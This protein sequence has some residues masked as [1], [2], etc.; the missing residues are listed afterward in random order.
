LLDSLLKR[1]KIMDSEEKFFKMYFEKPRRRA[2]LGRDVSTLQDLSDR[3]SLQQ[4][5]PVKC[6]HRLSTYASAS[7]SRFSPLT[8]I[9][10][11]IPILN[12]LPKYNVRHDLLND[13]VAG[14]TVAVMHIPQG[15]A[16]GLLAGVDPVVGI[17]TAFFPVLVYVL[18]GTMP[19]VSMGSFAVVSIL[20]SKTVTEWGVD[21]AVGDIP[22]GEYS[23]I[24][25]LAA[26]TF[27]VGVM[28]LLA[29]LCRLGFMSVLLTDTLVSA[30]TVGA[31][32]HVLTSQI[33]H[34]LGLSIARQSG[35]GQLVLTYVE[36]G[37]SVKS[38]N[39]VTLAISL[40]VM[41]TC[42]VA[43]R[44]IGPRLKAKCRF[45][46]PTQLALII[47]FTT[48]SKVLGFQENYHVKTI[49]DI[50]EIPVGLPSPSYPTPE[51]IPKVFGAC[52]VPG[53]VS[54]VVGLGLGKMF[55]QK[56]GYEV[57]SN[58][59]LIAQ[60]TSNLVGS[61]FSCIPMAGSL[62][63]SVVQEAS[64]CR[65]LLTSLTSALLLLSVMLYLGPFFLPLP[66]S[67]LASIIVA[68]LY[69]IFLK[70]GEVG[71]YWTLNVYEGCIWLLT[72]CSTVFI[73][74]DYG[75]IIGVISTLALTAVQG[76]TPR[77]RV[78]EQ[79]VEEDSCVW[80]DNQLF[81]TRGG[82]K[83]VQINGPLHFLALDMVRARIRA[84][85]GVGP[86]NHYKISGGDL[87]L[88][89]SGVSYLDYSAAGLV[90]WLDGVL[91]LEEGR[92]GL[93]A[94]PQQMQTL[95]TELEAFPTYTDA[96]VIL[97]G[98][99]NSSNISV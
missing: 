33:K 46:L 57:D 84:E 14:F 55:G 52:I 59:E 77:V 71:K 42:L 15:M 29:G 10:S 28:Q 25:V 82:T 49:Q 3:Y 93:V 75:L 54:F 64:G 88:D 8:L 22:E 47:I 58:Q 61:I 18:L 44:I 21:P 13:L 11:I 65:T 7:C 98:N 78:L 74:I 24:Q 12:W 9:T 23:R 1:L 27:C 35:A 56:H 4:T 34:I 85:L 80:L 79:T 26:V 5:S 48:L 94:T 87:V 2:D 68:S 30:F 41:G 76:L 67:V 43:D 6:H 73:D 51:L 19:H 31:S 60:G 37:Q 95:D 63:R 96:L 72:F 40:T 45:P 17:Y 83:V 81:K 70:V 36:I 66:V 90:R 32:L 39:L 16:Y 97:D 69:S 53:V 62:S 91:K 50:G 20:V 86:V 92:L 38:T 99:S 89:L